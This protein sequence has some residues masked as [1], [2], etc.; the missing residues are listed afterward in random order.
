[1]FGQVSKRQLTESDYKLWSTMHPEKLS[2]SGL[3]ASYSLHYESGNDTLFAKNTKN[4]KTFAFAGGRNGSFIENKLFLCLQLNGQLVITSLFDGT[5]QIVEGVSSY[6][7]N[8]EGRFLFMHKNSMDLT[9]KDLKTGANLVVPNVPLYSYNEIADAL[10]CSSD[11]KLLLISFKEGLDSKVISTESETSY[12]D[13][14][15]QRN[16]ISVAYFFTKGVSK[17]GYYN[18]P[19]KKLRVFDPS[20]FPDFPK[21]RS[22]YNA[23]F[24]PLLISEDGSKVFFGLKTITDEEM[25]TGIQL[26]NTKD[27]VLYPEKRFL[28][29]MKAVDEVG[30]WIME[31]NRFAAITTKEFPS[32]ILSGDQ[33]SALVYNLQT[34]EPLLCARAPIDFYLQD[35]SSGKRSLL[36]EK[37]SYDQSKLSFSPTGNFLAYFKDKHW[38][39]YD[40]KKHTKRNLTKDLKAS[41]AVEDSDRPGEKRACG[42]AGWTA[43]NSA[44]LLYDTFDVWLIKTDGSESKRITKGREDITQYRILPTTKLQRGTSNFSWSQQ[45]I[46]NLKEK[47]FIK[48][49][50]NSGTELYY[51]ESKIGLKTIVSGNNRLDNVMVSKDQ[52]T[53]VYTS[54]NYHQSPLFYAKTIGAKVSHQ[55]FASNPQQAKYDWGFSKK[56]KYTNSQGDLLQA[57][58]FYP[59]AY[60]PDINYP[61]VVKIY[62]KQSQYYNIYENPSLL[63]GEG[64]N[65]SNFTSQGY[66]VLLPDIGYEEGTTGRSALDCV[67]S[68]CKEVLLHEKVDAKRIGLLGHSFGGYETNFIITQTDFFA[69]ALAGAGVSDVVSNYFSV[70]ELF[71]KSNYFRFE[72]DQ[73]RLGV[74]FFENKDR[75]YRNSPI[76]FAE[77]VTTPLL[78]WSGTKDRTVPYQQSVEFY[79]ALRRLKKQ[80]LLFLYEGEGHSLSSKEYKID[81]TRRVEEWFSYYLKGGKRP[82]WF[83]ADR[84]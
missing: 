52:S 47:I 18:L 38:W 75:Y 81:L 19:T 30:V 54:E 80:A 43:D 14:V 6:S 22:L 10:V 57:A 40:F 29:N 70:L 39:V 33:K 74:S 62:E 7:I 32:M 11:S 42:M 79:L 46:Y 15:W 63:N 73:S 83:A 53:V 49:V 72:T 44:I 68:A 67:L 51:W 8:K 20:Q 45:G 71:G 78:S 66:F 37:Q 1:M 12:S 82:E 64:F 4:L 60:S 48:A 23:S 58:L 65:I 16:G 36:L 9:I 61:M 34:N 17:I 41:M 26:W 24:T 3:W 27:K 28:N 69:A 5:K 50:T 55:L 56:I 31:E 13:F 84:L 35:I 76:A 77:Q 59:A 25:P 21:D 2:D